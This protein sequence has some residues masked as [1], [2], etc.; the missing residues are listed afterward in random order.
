MPLTWEGDAFY[1]PG[2]SNAASESRAPAE[3]G[4]PGEVARAAQP[5]E[6][7]RGVPPFRPRRV[8]SRVTLKA[9][10]PPVGTRPSA[11]QTGR[12]WTSTGRA[13]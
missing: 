1:Q 8:T 5:V 12:N 4:R 13:G 11:G 7:R 3:L 2:C 6:E 9:H 10:H